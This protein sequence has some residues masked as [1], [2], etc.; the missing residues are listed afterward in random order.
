M[1]RF[2]LSD[3]QWAKLTPP[4]PLSKPPTGRPNKDHHLVVGAILWHLRTGAPWRDLPP[5]VAGIA[6]R[7]DDKLAA[8]YWTHITIAV[9]L[10]W[11]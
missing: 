10:L 7:Y 9:I 1:L 11:L 5:A 2:A 3:K 8:V 4:L 6:A